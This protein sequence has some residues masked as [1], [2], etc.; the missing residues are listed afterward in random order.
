M[1]NK[2]LINNNFEEHENICVMASYGTIIEYF[3][4]K[5]IKIEQLL[6]NYFEKYLFNI[7][8][9]FSD[10]KKKHD[11]IFKHFHIYC[12]EHKLRGFDYVK[13]LHEKNELNTRKYCQI[14]ESRASLEEIDDNCKESIRNYLT[15]YE[16]LVMVLYKVT[17]GNHAIIIGYDS[18]NK[19][20]FYK[21]S[22]NPKS[23]NDDILSQKEITEYIIFTK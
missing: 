6:S 14:F 13:R 2:E 3:S 17:G 4:N 18:D 5:E 11:L 22:T 16:A 23:Q 21:D 7:T 1:T 10:I 15:I 8:S 9:E 20:Y 12:K 19:N